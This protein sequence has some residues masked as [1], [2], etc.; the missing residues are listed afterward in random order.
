MP[1]GVIARAQAYQAREERA[2]HTIG[3]TRHSPRG[4]MIAAGPRDAA[5]ETFEEFVA[6]PAWRFC[7][8]PADAAKRMRVA[9]ANRRKRGALAG[10]VPPR[11]DLL[12][13]YIVRRQHRAV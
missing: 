5:L 10:A 8:G 1:A 12:D 3:I 6:V 2:N 11:H 9:A 4:A 7:P 13:K